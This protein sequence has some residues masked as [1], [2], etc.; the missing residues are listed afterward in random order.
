MLEH[1]DN[2]PVGDWVG[3]SRF[4]HQY[5]PDVIQHEPNTFSAAEIN[6]LESKGHKLKNIGR[7]YGN[8]Q[9]ILWD[10]NS[11]EVTAASDPRAFGKSQVSELVTE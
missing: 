2:K 7:E 1:F 9:A 6:A 4:H 11:G 5:L 3:R 10:K 8:M